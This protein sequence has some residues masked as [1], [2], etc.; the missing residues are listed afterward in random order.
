M[1]GQTCVYTQ[2]LFEE[3]VVSLQREIMIREQLLKTA[4]SVQD[5]DL[6][7][8]GISSDNQAALAIADETSQYQKSKHPGCTILSINSTLISCS[9]IMY[10]QNPADALTK[11]LTSA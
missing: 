4:E 2:I 5:G 1:N 9:S 6:Y 8:H 7:Q 11:A 3:N 10:P